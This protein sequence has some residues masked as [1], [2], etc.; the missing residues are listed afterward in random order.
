MKT[1][2][3]ALITAHSPEAKGRIERLF[4]T[5]QDRL[6]KEMR[7]AKIDNPREGNIFLKQVFI[8]KFNKH[9]AVVPTKEGNVHKSLQKQEKEHCD[10]IFS[11]HDQR[12]VNLDFTIQF[13]NKWYQL[14]EIQPT[15][16]RPL[17]R[18]VMET[19]LDRSV[20]IILNQHELAYQL[21]PEKPKKQRIKQPVILTTHTLNYKPPPEHPWRKFR[22]GKG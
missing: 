4:G 5:L 22:I 12:R 14:T 7:L 8:P 1:L 2:L 18:I 9:F 21:L 16:V 17:E 20:H 15:T 13:K 6:V 10:H 19:W 3:I 11:L